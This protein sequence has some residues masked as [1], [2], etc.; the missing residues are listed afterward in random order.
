MPGKS[1]YT[2]KAPGAI[3]KARWMAKAIYTLKIWMF[4]AQFH[5]SNKEEQLFFELSVFIA[6]T[7]VKAWFTCPRGVEAPR[8]DLDFPQ[9]LFKRRNRGPLWQAAYDKF[10]THLWFLSEKLVCFALFDSCI[11]SDGK[12]DFVAAMHSRE[13]DDDPPMRVRLLPNSPVTSLKLADFFSKK[14][15]RFLDIIGAE[16]SFL[17]K[18]PRKWKDDESYRKAESI[19]LHLKVVNDSAERG[20]ALIKR[21][22]EGNQLTKNEQERQDLLQVVSEH[23]KKCK[24]GRYLKH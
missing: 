13:G 11:S 9:T 15:Q 21:Y 10:A 16:T 24:D 12:A 20:V 19:A 5:L 1:P 3:S 22:L 6:S 14:S 2:F 17:G 18:H 4:Q 23:R 7:Y 8:R